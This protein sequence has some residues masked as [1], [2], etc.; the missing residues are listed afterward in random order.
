MRLAD[1]ADAAFHDVPNIELPSD[2]AQILG[3]VLEHPR[4]RPP[5]G[6]NAIVLGQ[7]AQDFIGHAFR[8]SG[9]GTVERSKGKHGN[10]ARLHRGRPYGLRQAQCGGE[11]SKPDSDK[12]GQAEGQRGAAGLL[13]G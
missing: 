5:Y 9:I 11:S 12:Q 13:D 4:R 10:A 2:A 3:L 8:K 1:C 7:I 6:L